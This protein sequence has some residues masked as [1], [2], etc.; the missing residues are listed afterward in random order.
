M[1]AEASESVECSGGMVA[2]MGMVLAR[3]QLAESASGIVA[4]RD[5]Q[6][7]L[8]GKGLYREAEK[9]AREQAL[10]TLATK[11]MPKRKGST[12]D[13]AKFK[14]AFTTW[15]RKREKE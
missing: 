11:D 12:L 15:M 13:K 1:A 4:A 2:K 6:A 14:E 5:R 3:A 7:A 9:V 10:G 8:V